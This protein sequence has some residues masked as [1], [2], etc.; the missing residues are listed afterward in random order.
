MKKEIKKHSDCVNYNNT[1]VCLRCKYFYENQPKYKENLYKKKKAK[2]KKSKIEIFVLLCG[3]IC[4][5]L[6]FFALYYVPISDE[7]IARF[8]IEQIL[9]I[10]IIFAVGIAFGIFSIV[11]FWYKRNNY[12]TSLQDL[13][14]QNEC[15]IRKQ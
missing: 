15:K 7:N 4:L 14:D 1:S 2:N 12:K 5:A 9:F 10:F 13:E 6:I 11:Y 8:S 3:L